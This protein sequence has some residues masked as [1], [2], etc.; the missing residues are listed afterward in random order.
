MRACRRTTSEV[1]TM[2][3][4][5]PDEV[6]AGAAPRCGVCGRRLRPGYRLRGGLLRC[7]WHTIL[8]RAVVKRALITALIVGTIITVINQGNVLLSH[9]FSREIVLKMC[10]SY[11][12]PF[13]V[14]TSG[15]LGMARIERPAGTA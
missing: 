15:A 2:T 9:G 10:L 6:H 8:H 4:A 7:T 3:S 5:L 13:C 11:C 12:V 1:N 14:S